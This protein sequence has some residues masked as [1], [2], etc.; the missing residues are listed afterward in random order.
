MGLRSGQW[1]PVSHGVAAILRRSNK[2]A[3]YRYCEVF[4]FGS[5][6]PLHGD[7]LNL[8]QSAILANG[9]MRD[10]MGP[11]QQSVS[12]VFQANFLSPEPDFLPG[13]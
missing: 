10:G 9:Y 12:S 11:C 7:A 2:M 6:C 1:S 5:M 3:G 8:H 4:Q 13:S